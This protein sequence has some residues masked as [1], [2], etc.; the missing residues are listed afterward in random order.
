MYCFLLPKRKNRKPDHSLHIVLAESVFYHWRFNFSNVLQLRNCDFIHQ[1]DAYKSKKSNL[2]AR[3]Y[4]AI[5]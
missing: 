5:K 2:F 3:F 1:A 4:I